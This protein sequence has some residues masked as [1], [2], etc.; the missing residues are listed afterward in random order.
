ME[1]QVIALYARG[2]STR[3]IGAHLHQIHGV[4]ISPPLSQ[5]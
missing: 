1:D 5:F 3:D 4:D 2:V